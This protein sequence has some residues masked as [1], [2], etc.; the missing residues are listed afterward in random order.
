MGKREVEIK[1]GEINGNGKEYYGNK[2]LK[3]TG[4]YKNGKTNGQGIL[5]YEFFG[6]IQYI[7]EFKNGMKH[8]TGK[9]Y[10]KCGNL[11][12][13]GEFYEDKILKKI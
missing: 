11:I 5:Y 10:D 7:G 8:G 3:Y 4:M 2:R 9:E 12:Y 6:Y 13:Q 1:N